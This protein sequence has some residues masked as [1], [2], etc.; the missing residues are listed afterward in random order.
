MVN[1][2]MIGHCGLCFPSYQNCAAPPFLWEND[3][4]TTSL[5][6]SLTKL[7]TFVILRPW[8]SWGI[9]VLGVDEPSSPGLEWDVGA[10]EAPEW[11]W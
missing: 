5:P 3:P 1:D 7:P 9:L 8:Q 11:W 6:Q 4:K 10:P 2:C